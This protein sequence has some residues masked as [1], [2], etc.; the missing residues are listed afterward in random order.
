MIQYS[1]EGLYLF[2]TTYMYIEGKKTIGIVGAR[3][4]G[5]MHNPTHTKSSNHFY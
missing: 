1:R 2:M 4:K 3:F 5:N